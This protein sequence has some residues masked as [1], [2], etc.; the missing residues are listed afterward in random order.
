MILRDEPFDFNPINLKKLA[1]ETKLNFQ[2]LA[3][4]K[5]IRIIV[6]GE[7]IDKN[8]D[9][10]GHEGLMRQ[11]FVNLIDN[12]IKY[13]ARGSRII[14]SARHAVG[15]NYLQVSNRGISVPPG[16]REEIFLQGMRLKKAKM[17]VPDGTGLGLWIV[18]KILA[19]HGAEITCTEVFEKGSPRT[20]FQIFFS[21]EPVRRSLGRW[22]VS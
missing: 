9:V 20:A 4:E 22:R 15:G 13:S 16:L 10:W 19:A 14:V 17:A 3:R 6:L 5:D 1:V 12:A 11:V 2:H 21:S 8:L 18:R 7:E